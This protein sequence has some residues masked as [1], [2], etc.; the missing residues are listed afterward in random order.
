L[1]TATT[2]LTEGTNPGEV[3]LTATNVSATLAEYG[4][5]VK[6]SRF[7]TLNGIDA[8]NAEKIEVVG[9]NMGE[10]MDELVRNELFTGATVQYQGAKAALSALAASDVLKGR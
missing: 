3:A 7:L 9:Q 4:N 2:A 5:V 10:T 1:A 6:I 8:N